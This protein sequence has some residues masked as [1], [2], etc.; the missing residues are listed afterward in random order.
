MAMV[1]RIGRR[2][3]V[4]CAML[5]RDW[6]FGAA[7]WRLRH[8]ASARGAVYRVAFLQSMCAM[9]ALRG[10]AAYAAAPP[11]SESGQIGMRISMPPL[12]RPKIKSSLAQCAR[13]DKPARLAMVLA[14]IQG[15]GR[16]PPFPPGLQCRFGNDGRLDQLRTLVATPVAL[17]WARAKAAAL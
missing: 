15:H 6:R 9:G 3:T 1:E 4:L 13:Q 16:A 8:R 2:Q 7:V 5:F 14:R 11:P 17:V 12:Q 10:E